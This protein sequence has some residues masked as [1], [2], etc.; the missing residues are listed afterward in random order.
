MFFFVCH[1]SK[2]SVKSEEYLNGDLL[3]FLPE[4]CLVSE[5][6][7]VHDFYLHQSTMTEP[8]RFKFRLIYWVVYQG[9]DAYFIL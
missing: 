6:A 3:C 7:V 4:I 2:W 9:Y 8:S 1:L 5:S